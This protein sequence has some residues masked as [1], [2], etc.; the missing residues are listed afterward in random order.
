MLGLVYQSKG[1]IDKKI[2]DLWWGRPSASEEAMYSLIPRCKRNVFREQ[3]LVCQ[4]SS[5]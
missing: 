1:I 3:L 2:G 4:G 5:E